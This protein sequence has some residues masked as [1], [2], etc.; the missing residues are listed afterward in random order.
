MLCDNL[1]LFFLSL[2]NHLKPFL[3]FRPPPR[4]FGHPCYEQF[5]Y[6]EK[7]GFLTIQSPIHRCRDLL[8]MHCRLELH[9]AI[10]FS[11]SLFPPSQLSKLLLSLI[12]EVVDLHLV[13]E[14]F[15]IGRMNKSRKNNV[16]M[17]MLRKFYTFQTQK[18]LQKRLQLSKV[19]CL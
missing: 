7:N 12:C 15:T 2:H 8:W 14:A 1:F 9:A 19:H 6:E 18:R 17:G 4:L 5:S 16:K 3:K 11:V 10:V 13:C